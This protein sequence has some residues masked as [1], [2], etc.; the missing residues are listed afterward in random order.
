M[1]L[2]MFLAREF[3]FRAYEKMLPEVPDSS[4]SGEVRDA[5]IVFVHTEAE[6]ASRLE[7]VET[8]AAKNIKWICGKMAF[9]TVVLHSFNHLGASKA[10]PRVAEEILARIETRLRRVG[11]TVH[12]TPFGHVCEWELAVLGPS[13][14]KV[15]KEF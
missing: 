7:D 9:R 2:L 12:A 3:R 6:D 5:A 14:A 8:K 1:K 13:I 15:F 10:R 11:Y 4:A